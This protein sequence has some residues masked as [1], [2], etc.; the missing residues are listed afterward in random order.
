MIIIKS[1]ITGIA[2]NPTNRKIFLTIL[3]VISLIFLWVA[4]FYPQ[5]YGYG[6]V[7]VADRKEGIKPGTISGLMKKLEIIILQFKNPGKTADQIENDLNRCGRAIELVSIEKIGGRVNT[8]CKKSFPFPAKGTRYRRKLRN[9]LESGDG[10][11]WFFMESIHSRKKWCC[12]E[13]DYDSKRGKFNLKTLLNDEVIFFK[14]DN[15]SSGGYLGDYDYPDDFRFVGVD[16]RNENL[17]TNQCFIVNIPEKKAEILNFLP[18]CKNSILNKDEMF[19]FT[20]AAFAGDRR[21]IHQ[22]IIDPSQRNNLSI[23]DLEKKETGV[24]NVGY[25]YIHLSLVYLMP[26][27]VD[28]DGS[29]V[30]FLTVDNKNRD[31]SLDNRRIS[32]KMMDIQT[33]KI[34]KIIDLPEGTRFCASREG[35]HPILKWSPLADSDQLVFTTLTTG[36][37]LINVRDKKVQKDLQI[38]STPKSIRW[39]PDGKKIGILGRDG[40]LYIYDLEKDTLE[41]V[42]EDSDYFDFFWVGREKGLLDSA[43]DRVKSVL[44]GIN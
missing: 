19:E 12:I 6:L 36:L 34:T 21:V 7:A 38:K 24:V 41:K 29:R 13:I 8:S 9:L 1:L 27:G 18:S 37:M 22:W 2:G 10:N 30:A 17:L 39:S 31:G 23:I 33:E 42:M 25:G 14:N 44:Q 15:N 26:I 35:D 28:K 4:N 3:L 11:K 5:H 43:I 16:S 20:G 32:L 40:A